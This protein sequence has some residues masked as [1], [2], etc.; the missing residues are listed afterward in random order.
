[1]D[2]KN[3]PNGSLEFNFGAQKSLAGVHITNVK[4]EKTAQEVIEEDNSKTVLA[5]GNYVYNGKFQSG[6][7]RMGYWEADKNNAEAASV[8]V[9]N[10]NNSRRLKIVAPEGTSAEKPVVVT[11]D[12]LALVDGQEY[13]MSFDAEGPADGALALTVGGTSYQ[14]ELSGKE[15][16]YN[17]TIVPEEKSSKDLHI[18]VTKPGVYYLDNVRIVENAMIKNGS[19][20]AGT[21]GY[22]VYVDASAAAKVGVDSLTEDN[23]LAIDVNDT[24]TDDWRIQVKQNDVK[25]EKGKWYTL[26]YKAKATRDR[27]IR[28]IMQGL[29]NRGWSVY[30]DDS[31]GT[32]DL[33]NEYQT[34]TQTFQMRADDDP[35]AFLSICA[36]SLN[37]NRITEPH[38]IYVDDVSLVETE[39]PENT[40]V[41][42]IEAG[43]NQLKNTDFATG[44]E[45]WDGFGNLNSPAKGSIS[46][47]AGVITAVI[48][49]AGSADW[50]AQLKQGGIVLEKGK[51]YKLS[52]KASSTADRSIKADFLDP[53]NGYDW[54]GGGTFNLTNEEKEYEVTFTVDKD[55]NPNMYLMLSMGKIGDNTPAST[56]KISGLSLVKMG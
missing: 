54:Y 13:A 14:A 46:A 18:V 17:S 9:T 42:E 4:L 48:E 25:L 52:F 27:Q 7:G 55:T 26:T 49:D 56:V 44:T 51:T 1:M 22:E 40:D 6:E 31:K 45:N 10:E 30:S 24:S 35:H 38:S 39:A 19:F 28:V 50:N 23:A 15:K 8:S 20:D 53:A 41:P 16:S 2:G 21:S 37:G 32:V 3:D 12:G 34:F 11:Q 5:D 36:G 47:S 43:V 29:E 33:T